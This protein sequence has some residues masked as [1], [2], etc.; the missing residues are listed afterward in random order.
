MGTN[1]YKTV[2]ISLP[3]PGEEKNIHFNFPFYVLLGL[4]IC[5]G[6]INS[7]NSILLTCYWKTC[8]TQY[9]GEG[10][11]FLAVFYKYLA[12][13]P[14]TISEIRVRKNWKFRPFSDPFYP[15]FGRLHVTPVP[16]WALFREPWLHVNSM[17][18]W[19]LF[20][21]PQLHVTPGAGHE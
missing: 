18:M 20:W 6:G 10:L 21:E 11:L 7:F 4:D 13:L 8:E 16:M 3:N 12:G 9:R 5:W 17:P 2:P 19:A 15:K 14:I 1:K